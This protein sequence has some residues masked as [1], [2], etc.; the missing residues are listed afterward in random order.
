MGAPLPRLTRI[1]NVLKVLEYK[2]LGWERIGS[3][4]EFAELLRP[5]I[6]PANAEIF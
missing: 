6:N 2:N 4:K 3:D 5:L 1:A